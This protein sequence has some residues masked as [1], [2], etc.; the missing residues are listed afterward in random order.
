MA[1]S[2]RRMIF[3]TEAGAPAILAATAALLLTFLR[4]AAMRFS[5][6]A[7]ACQVAPPLPLHLHSAHL[8]LRQ[9]RWL[10][11]ARFSHLHSL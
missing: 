11:R 2:A 5:L 3:C 9:W 7:V 10:L 1:E 4:W 8:I 6:D